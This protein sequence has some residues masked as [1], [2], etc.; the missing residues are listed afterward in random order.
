MLGRGIFPR[1]FFIISPF[2]IPIYEIHY[3]FTIDL[4]HHLQNLFPVLLHSFFVAHAD[5]PL[6]VPWLKL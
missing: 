6:A 1:P 5:P 3:F 4:L 2:D